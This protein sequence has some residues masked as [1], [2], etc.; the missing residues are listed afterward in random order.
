[1]SNGDR[2]LLLAPDAHSGRTTI[3]IVEG[4]LMEIQVSRLE[5]GTVSVGVVHE[6]DEYVR[7]TQLKLEESLRE[8][9]RLRSIL[10]GY[11]YGES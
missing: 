4:F 11:G 8:V 5:N 2:V 3:E 9:S 7:L 1:M 10:S 6:V